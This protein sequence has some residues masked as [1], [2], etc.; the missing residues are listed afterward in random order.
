M[1]I[2]YCVTGATFGG[3]VAHVIGLMQADV[4]A[5]HSV[6]VV[7]AP[8]PRLMLEAKN[9]NVPFFP[10][11]YFVFGVQPLQDIRTLWPVF[12]AVRKFKP[13]IISAHSTKAGYAARLAGMF[14]KKP[15][16]FTAH[17]WS[18]TEGRSNRQRYL[19]ALAERLAAWF[20]TAIICVSEYDQGLALKFKVAPPEKLV[21]IHNGVDPAPLLDAR[22]ERVR[23]EFGLGKVPVLAMVGR[24]TPQKDPLTLL[25]ACRLLK[26][27][28]RLMMVGDGE[29]RSK[30]EKFVADNNLGDKVTFT[31]NRTDIPDILA[32]SDILVLDS[33]WEGLPMVIIEAQ[34]AGVPVVA[35][36]V[37]GV[38]ELIEDGVTGFLVP[39]RNPQALADV[40]FNLIVNPKLLRRVA[41]AARD[42]A[43][44]EF[45][46]KRMLTKTHQL[47]EDILKKKALFGHKL[48]G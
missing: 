13:D 45:T 34:M 1:K 28:F 18:F 40:L 36:S 8:E 46:L 29:L 6:G 48:N 37:G 44:H 21:V 16:I 15:V 3:A 41:S 42:K 43:L 35:S 20:T 10:N 39:P 47:Y 2:L 4:K 31:G 30:A 33:R 5:G 7:A 12:R 24:L 32:A 17:G 9:I 25:E 11:P 27:D 23:R 26:T 38:P 14:L 19:L 22:G